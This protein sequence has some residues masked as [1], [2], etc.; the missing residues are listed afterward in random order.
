MHHELKTWPEHFQ[1]VV[2][3]RKM[4]ELRENDREFGVWDTLLLR[5]WSPNAGRYTG[6]SVKV[7]VSYMVTGPWLAAGMVAMSISLHTQQDA[8]WQPFNTGECGTLRRV[9]PGCEPSS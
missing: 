8:R 3:E 7:I 4:F 6:R 9:P 1:A 5:E 2:D